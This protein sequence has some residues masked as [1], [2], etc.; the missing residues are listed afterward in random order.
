MLE[1]IIKLFYL[2]A[3]PIEV[4]LFFSPSKKGMFFYF[5]IKRKGEVGRETLMNKNHQ[6]GCLLHTP[7]PPLVIQPAT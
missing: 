5:E 7:L 6:S 1:I 2:T 4:A 3:S